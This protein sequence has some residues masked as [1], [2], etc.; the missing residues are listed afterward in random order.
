MSTKCFKPKLEKIQINSIKNNVGVQTNN[1]KKILQTI[2]EYY[3]T[4]N[5]IKTIN[6]NT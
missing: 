6:E 4:L 5:K 2:Q 1:I 3:T